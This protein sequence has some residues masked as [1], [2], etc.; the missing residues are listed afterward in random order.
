MQGTDQ[1][2]LAIDDEPE[3]LKLRE[4]KSDVPEVAIAGAQWRMPRTRAGNGYA[5]MADAPR[6]TRPCPR[7]LADSAH[8]D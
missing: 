4:R 5:L 6:I 3:M 1:L 7:R 2:V 8:R